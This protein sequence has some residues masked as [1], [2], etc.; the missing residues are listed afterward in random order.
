MCFLFGMRGSLCARCRRTSIR[1][2]ACARELPPNHTI[3][4]SELI[5]RWLAPTCCGSCV[6]LLAT[7]FPSVSAIG[8]LSKDLRT[9]SRHVIRL[10]N[11]LVTEAAMRTPHAY[12]E[13]KPHS[14]SW[15][16]V[17]C[18]DCTKS[19]HAFW[20]M[21]IWTPR[22][23][24]LQ[25]FEVGSRPFAISS[26]SL[27][28]AL[29]VDGGT[30]ARTTSLCQRC[31]ALDLVGRWHTFWR[32]RELQSI[33]IA[34]LG[35]P[36]TWTGSTCSLCQFFL[37]ALL[38]ASG[39]DCIPTPWLREAFTLWT[40]IFEPTN[41]HSASDLNA[42]NVVLLLMMN[43][44]FNL[45]QPEPTHDFHLCHLGL[46]LELRERSQARWHVRAVC[47]DS[48]SYGVIGGWLAACDSNHRRECGLMRLKSVEDL[49]LIDCESLSVERAVPGCRYA[50]LSYVWGS[51]NITPHLGLHNPPRT[52][53]D[54]I[55]VTRKL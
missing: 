6:T 28:M 52:I 44:P 53:R 38:S 8:W 4:A 33:L 15:H 25:Y 50:A 41:V 13:S 37:D 26:I 31:A 51:A 9:K 16:D 22:Q 34:R 55:E 11:C 17:V 40:W 32:S 2:L 35:A 42:G 1:D 10:T 27:A 7:R 24:G 23:L 49:L 45:G 43:V 12:P 3:S 48:V 29:V 39:S 47:R 54:A 5:S 46:N 36:Q 14:T 30:T 21:L 19:D 20:Q 18:S